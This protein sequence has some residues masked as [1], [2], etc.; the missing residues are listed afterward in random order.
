MQLKIIKKNLQAQINGHQMLPICLY[1][2][3]GLGKSA[4]IKQAA[5][6]LNVGFYHLAMSSISL[7]HMQ[8]IPEFRTRDDLNQ[9]SISGNNQVKGTTWTIPEVIVM[10]NSIA[11]Q[12]NG[13]VVLMD[14]FHTINP[15]IENVMY[16]FLLERRIGDYKLH[17]K[18]A[19][20]AAMNHDK[21]S[22]GG[23][24]N[25]AAVK[26]RLRLMEYQ[27]NF[28]IWFDRFGRYLHP[29]ISSFLQQNS[30]YI[31]EPETVNLTPNASPRSWTMLSNEFSLYKLEELTSEVYIPLVSGIASPEV[32][33]A[34]DK[35]MVYYNKMNFDKIIKNREIPDISKLDEI[36]KPIFGKI[37]AHVR[38]DIIGIAD[39]STYII[40]LIKSIISQED[41]EGV[42]GFMGQE[43]ATLFKLKTN[44]EKIEPS[45]DIALDILLNEEPNTNNL[46]KSEKDKIAK[47]KMSKEEKA[48]FMKT[49][50]NYI[51]K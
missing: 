20:I 27:F 37:I 5:D 46:S 21:N 25:S 19:L 40:D 31:T 17:P 36:T 7:E 30:N 34:F 39:G 45:I 2:S 49:I 1:G 28:D 44:K 50:Y 23:K 13:C 26:S 8:G 42:L 15:S 41:N 35:H 18:V 10:I 22:G 24:F 47:I 43:L 33:T 9:Y 6:E 51:I 3:P 29:F 12:N 48:Q 16:E 11:E 32:S 38:Q 14:D 4:S